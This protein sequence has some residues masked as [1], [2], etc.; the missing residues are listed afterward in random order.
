[1]TEAVS[2]ILGAN[3][4][5]DVVRGSPVAIDF[6]LE[7]KNADIRRSLDNLKNPE[8]HQTKRLAISNIITV[9]DIT[10]KTEIRP[11]WAKKPELALWAKAQCTIKI[12]IQFPKPLVLLAIWA[13]N[14]GTFCLMIWP[15]NNG[16]IIS[17][18]SFVNNGLSGILILDSIDK[19]VIATVGTKRTDNKLEN[20]VAKIAFDVFPFDTVENTTADETVVGKIA[21]IQKPIFNSLSITCDSGTIRAPTKIGKI[22]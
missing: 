3:A 11:N 2:V 19:Y 16:A 12:I 13:E 1:M 14:S 17:I 6:W 22:I 4:N 15:N 5:I 10:L 20:T 9:N 21:S 18:K 7:Q 8:D